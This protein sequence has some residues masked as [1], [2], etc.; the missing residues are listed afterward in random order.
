MPGQILMPVHTFSRADPLLHQME[1]L[2][3]KNRKAILSASGPE[4]SEKVVERHHL[5]GIAMQL[6]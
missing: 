3:A 2:S 4:G 1:V 6:P 5:V